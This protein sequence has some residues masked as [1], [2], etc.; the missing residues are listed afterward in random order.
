MTYWP[1]PSDSLNQVSDGIILLAGQ[2]QERAPKAAKLFKK[3]YAPL[4]ILANDGVRSGWSKKYQ[5]NLYATERSEELLVQLGVP[6]ESIIKLPYFKSGTIYDALAV[7]N[8]ITEHGL[9]SIQLVTSDYHA[10]RALLIF[11]RVFRG[12]PVTI[13]A[14]EAPSSFISLPR[15]MEPIK[16]AYYYVRFGLFL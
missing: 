16:I 8:Y 14:S 2:Y 3:G 11:R 9:M 5:L 10:Y 6:R 4:I 13:A 15:L 12:T 1:M 7:K